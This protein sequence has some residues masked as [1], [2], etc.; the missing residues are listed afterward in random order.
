MSS[1][2]VLGHSLSVMSFYASTHKYLSSIH[3]KDETPVEADDK[4]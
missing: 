3:I 4:T 2:D 1:R